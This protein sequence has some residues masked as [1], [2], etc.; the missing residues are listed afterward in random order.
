MAKNT[1]FLFKLDLLILSVLKNNDKYG[2]EIIKEISQKTDNIIIPKHGTMY[3]TIYKLIENEYI[4]SR[5]VNVGNKIRVY[6]H[7]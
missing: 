3:P 6:Y 5:N 2:Y 1:N 7:L 4:T